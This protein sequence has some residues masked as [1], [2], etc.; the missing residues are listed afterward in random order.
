MAPGNV[1]FKI[2]SKTT[3]ERKAIIFSLGETTHTT[4]ANIG[5]NKQV[6]LNCGVITSRCVKDFAQVYY[7]NVRGLR[8]K[9]MSF[10]TSVLCDDHP[11]IVLSETCLTKDIKNSELFPTVY[12]V[13]RCD[14]GYTS[15]YQR[16]GGVLTAVKN[17]AT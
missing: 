1:Y 7:Q 6:R 10:H 12:D 2:F 3:H 4:N 9:L 14:R 15:E 11:Y 13:Y 16:G 8:S 17:S 5:E